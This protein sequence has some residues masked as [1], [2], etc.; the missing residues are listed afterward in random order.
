MDKIS[1]CK[2]GHLEAGDPKEFGTLMGT[3]AG[4][5]PHIDIWGG[6]CGTWETHL[7]ETA[8]NVRTARDLQAV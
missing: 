5:Y 3:L 4:K 2:L 8:R 6:C 1:L 7:D